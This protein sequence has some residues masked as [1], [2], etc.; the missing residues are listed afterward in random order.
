MK[1][2]THIQLY[3]P[4]E[5]TGVPELREALFA[6]NAAVLELMA[7]LNRSQLLVDR[8]SMRMAVI[9]Q[10]HLMGDEAALRHHLVKLVDDC[11]LV[12]QHP[13]KEAVH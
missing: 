10:A 9:A 6:A 4:N 7:L 1:K 13:P 5:I 11:A 2:I 8:L 3:N 12:P